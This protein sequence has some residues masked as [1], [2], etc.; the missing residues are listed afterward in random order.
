LEAEPGIAV[1][2]DVVLNQVLIRFGGDLG[3]AAG[4]ALTHATIGRIRADGVCFT[5]GASWRGREV[6]RL[7]VAGYETDEQ[8]ATRSAEAIVTAYRAVR[9]DHARKPLDM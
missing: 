1:V 2:N 4:D 5:G 8:E 6:M 3:D 7:S 9:Q